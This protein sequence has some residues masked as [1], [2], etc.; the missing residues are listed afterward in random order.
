MTQQAVSIYKDLR[1]PFRPDVRKSAK[2]HLNTNIA[3][4][5]GR[6]NSVNL[7]EGTI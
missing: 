2:V 6:K 7:S 4:K 1:T 3:Y 5:S